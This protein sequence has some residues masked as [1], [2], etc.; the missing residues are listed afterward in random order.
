[1]D[2]IESGSLPKVLLIVGGYSNKGVGAQFIASML[3]NYPQEQIVRFSIINSENSLG[4]NDLG[5]ATHTFKSTISALPILSS[6]H[7]WKFKRKDLARCMEQ[8]SNLMQKNKFDIIW[9]ILNGFYTTQLANELIK[10][11]HHP[12]VVHVWDD[13]EYKADQSRIDHFTRKHLMSLFENI[14]AK[15]NRG[16]TVSDSMGRMYKNNYGLKST[17]MVFCPPQEALI[18]PQLFKQNKKHIEIVFA[19]SLYAYKEWNAFLDAVEENNDN[20]D[21]KEI[22][23]HCI[24]NVSRWTKKRAYVKYEA[25]KPV[26][27]AAKAINKADLAYLP[28]WMSNKFSHA[29]QTAFPSKLSLYVASGTPVLYHGPEVST[30]AEFLIDYRVGINCHSLDSQKIINSIHSCLSSE[31][32]NQYIASRNKALQNVF[33]SNRSSEIFQESIELAIETSSNTI[34]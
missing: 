4:E 21:N 11:N 29:V 1:M 5:Y 3:S 8:L 14:L 10:K 19:G 30:P 15:A 13:P 33:R 6:L 32:K 16:V 31:F 2:E 9:V 26:G 28:Y 22:K 12:M 7:Y 34:I 18:S 20:P 23:I 25:L 17:T 24:G 27:D